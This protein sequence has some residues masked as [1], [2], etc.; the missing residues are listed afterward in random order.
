[1]FEC[2]S[3]FFRYYSNFV[4]QKKGRKKKCMRRFPEPSPRIF[5]PKGSKS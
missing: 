2:Y 1:M 5:D 3:S 4:V